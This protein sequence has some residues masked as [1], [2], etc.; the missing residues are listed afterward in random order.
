MIDCPNGRLNHSIIAHPI[1]DSKRLG[2]EVIC[3]AGLQA[4]VS[5][6]DN[7]M[8]RP[9]R[10]AAASRPRSSILVSDLNGLT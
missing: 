6:T 7:F 1:I 5:V 9:C 10:S 2:F 8:N 3:S 4:C